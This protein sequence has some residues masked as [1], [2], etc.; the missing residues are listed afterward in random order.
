MSDQGGSR[1]EEGDNRVVEISP[2]L[3]DAP[4]DVTIDCWLE[5]EKTDASR[6]QVM[7]DARA[8]QGAGGGCSERARQGGAL[9][10][11]LRALLC[12]FWLGER[13][14]AVRASVHPPCARGRSLAT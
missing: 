2:E 11:G 10:I 1:W 13:R 12:R 8:V 9:P 4:L 3:L 7:L 14:G 5:F 6:V